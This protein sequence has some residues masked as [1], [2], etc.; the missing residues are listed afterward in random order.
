MR[1]GAWAAGHALPPVLPCLS[2][3]TATT[4]FFDEAGAVVSIR[5]SG[6]EPKIK[7]RGRLAGVCWG[8]RCVAPCCLHLLWRCV[9]ELLVVRF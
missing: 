5:A 4:S 1:R 2:R 9:R 7:V 8:P 3:L 6:T